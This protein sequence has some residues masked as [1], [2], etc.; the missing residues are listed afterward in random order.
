MYMACSVRVTTNLFLIPSFLSPLRK[1]W[2]HSSWP[3]T[4]SPP[5]CLPP[6][7]KMSIRLTFRSVAA[8]TSAYSAW[9]DFGKQRH[10][11]SVGSLYL[12]SFNDLHSQFTLLSNQRRIQATARAAP[13]TWALLGPELWGL[14]LTDYKAASG[15]RRELSC[16]M[17]FYG[18]VHVSSWFCSSSGSAVLGESRRGMDGW[19][20]CGR[21]SL[22]GP[23][24]R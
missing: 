15:T 16:L 8:S 3:A 14:R 4:T 5:P 18:K 2:N 1:G 24:G 13:S 11:T 12:F 19:M 7:L 21:T 9:L 22:D 10:G 17:R 6:S 23:T 20:L